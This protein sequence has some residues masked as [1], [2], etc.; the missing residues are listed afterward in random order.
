MPYE[1][2]I[3]ELKERAVQSKVYTSFQLHGL[4]IAQL[5]KD[6]SHRSLYI[7]LAKQYNVEDLRRLAKSI[8]ENRNVSNKGAYFMTVFAKEKEKYGRNNIPARKPK[9]RKVPADKNKKV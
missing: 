8:A 6:E 1:D 4:E 9:G 3:K 2:Y 7:R 5:L